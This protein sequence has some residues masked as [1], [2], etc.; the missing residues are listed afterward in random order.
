MV[1][2][3]LAGEMALPFRSV[4]L[5]K[6]HPVNIALH[7]EIESVKKR[8]TSSFAICKT[9]HGEACAYIE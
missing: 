3:S 4:G 5:Y 7:Y 2:A 1:L 6:K 9:W 8:T